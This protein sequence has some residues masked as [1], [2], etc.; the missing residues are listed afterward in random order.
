MEQERKKITEG[1]K[2]VLA[3]YKHKEKE[4]GRMERG[5]EASPEQVSKERGMTRDEHGRETGGKVCKQAA[6]ADKGGFGLPSVPEESRRDGGRKGG[7]ENLCVCGQTT[8][9]LE[10]HRLIKMHS[11]PPRLPLSVS[12]PHPLLLPLLPSITWLPHSL[13]LMQAAEGH[14]PLMFW[15]VVCGCQRSRQPYFLNGGVTGVNKA[16]WPSTSLHLSLWLRQAN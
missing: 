9:K 8:Q 15:A 2:V 12:F 4:R 6:G 16:G 11:A 7:G 1:R 10:R 5:C 3:Y 13:S 14:G